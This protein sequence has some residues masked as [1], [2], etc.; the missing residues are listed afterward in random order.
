MRFCVRSS[1]V[2]RAVR[3]RS[4]LALGAVLGLLLVGCQKRDEIQRYTVKKLPRAE[5]PAVPEMPPRGMPAGHGQ[6]SSERLL[7]AIAPHGS[8]FWVFKLAGPKDLASAQMEEFLSLVQSLK[9][10]GDED[11]TPEWT[12]PEGW[13][14]QKDSEKTSTRF[15]TLLAKQGDDELPVS[16]TRLPFPPDRPTEGVP[17]MIVN[18]WCEQLGLAEKTPADLKAEEQPKGA[19]VQLLDVNGM[20]V[21]LVNF[22]AAETPARSA[23]VATREPS[24]G[25]PKW[26]VPEGWKDTPGNQFSVAAFAVTDGKQAIKTTVSR[27]GGDL[28]GNLNRWRDQVKLE[29][30][31]ADEAAKSAKKLTVDGQEGT[32]VDFVGVDK[33]TSKP[34]CL[35]GAIVPQGDSAWFFKLTGDVELAQREKANFEA[36]VQSVKFEK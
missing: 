9:F 19:E 13:S 3:V 4:C 21:T 25:Q 17:L 1:F 27:A 22:L 11:S 5:R 33:N 16:V 31:S 23:P 36:F 14:E 24:R 8:T 10:S 26:T 28:L 29:P 35:I 12:L 34:M 18:L 15:A 7:G 20:Q 32:F 30:W 2:G 6:T